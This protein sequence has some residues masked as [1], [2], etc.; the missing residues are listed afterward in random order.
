MSEAGIQ[1]TN[2]DACTKK[3]TCAAK[4]YWADPFVHLFARDK[5]SPAQ[6]SNSPLI[7]RG[8]WAR[9]RAIETVVCNFLSSHPTPQVLS[10]GAGW[11]TLYF[12]LRASG[13]VG[14]GC[15]WVEVDF[16]D[17][18]RRKCATVARS[19]DLKALLPPD[20]SASDAELHSRQYSVL[21]AD[22]RQPA[23]L[24]QQLS[25]VPLTPDAPL[26]LL[27]ECV[28]VYMESVESDNLL[29][30]LLATFPMSSVLLYE[31]IRPDD[32][33]G[34]MM[35]RNLQAR[36][37]PFR[38]IHA[39]PTVADQQR[40]YEALGLRTLALDMNAVYAKLPATE[41]QRVERLEWMDELEEW[42]II[43]SHYCIVVGTNHADLATLT[44]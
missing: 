41:R 12:R 29:R 39:H 15:K 40:R 5:A 20:T 30:S 25:N 3:A 22:L 23:A 32:A 17:V 11:D 43:L 36:G 1:D 10:L 34:Q 28:L 26:L 16:A 27:A 13:T 6:P 44:L 7:N 35:V 38:G 31:A 8:Y 18:T 19:P 21:A 2:T 24:L 37:C 9:V 42:Q 14:D 4:G 33:F